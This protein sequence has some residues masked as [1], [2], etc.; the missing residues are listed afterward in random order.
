MD[1]EKLKVVD[2][3][4]ELSKRGLD[5]KGV[6]SVLVERLRKAIDEENANQDQS[7]TNTEVE[8]DV[9][10]EEEERS[11]KSTKIPQT[12]KKSSRLSK[13][14]AVVTPQREDPTIKKRRTT[15]TPYSRKQTSPKKSDQNDMSRESSPAVSESTIQEEASTQ[16]ETIMP[17]ATVLIEKMVQ[18]EK[19]IHEEKTVPKEKAMQEDKVEK[20]EETLKEEK[21]I[22]EN[23]DIKEE[24]T[25]K[26][27]RT[28]KEEGAGKGD[29]TPQEEITIKE[30]KS[31]LPEKDN[32][33]E[34]KEPLSNVEHEGTNIMEVQKE[35]IKDV[36]IEENT[37]NESKTNISQIS[38]VQSPVKS[39]NIV[40]PTKESKESE[41]SKNDT[42]DIVQNQKQ[43]ETSKMEEEVLES[44]GAGKD[45]NITTHEKENDTLKVNKNKCDEMDNSKVEPIAN[46]K[47]D[48]T[49]LTDAKS[50]ES[51]CDTQSDIPK[52]EQP[53]NDTT[54]E[55]KD[56]D[57][58][59]SDKME[60][61][62]QCM[63]K[64]ILPSNE[65]EMDT[66]IDDK[67]DKEDVEM[68]EIKHKEDT[69]VVTKARRSKTTVV[70]R[71]RKRKRSP[72]PLEDRHDSPP[73]VL[74]EN[75]PDID[76]AALILSWYDSDL[77]LVI[78][79]EGFFTATPMHNDGFS[80]MWA[81]ARASYGFLC[82]KVYYEAK[83]VDHCPVNTENEEYPHVLRIGW[84]TPYTSMQLGEEK[85]SF[86]YCSTGKKLTDNNYEDYGV[87]FGK[88][89]IIGCYF[90]ATSESDVVLTYT[91]NGKDQGIAFS[92]SKQ[93]LGDK[94]LFPHILSKNCSFACN[95]GQETP[96]TEEILQD[97]VSI[98]NV[99]SQ[100][101][102]PGPRRPE[103]KEECEVIMMC[104]LPAC[105]KTTWATKYAAEHP[106]KMYNVLGLGNLIDKMKDPELSDKEEYDAQWKILIQKC[107]YALDKLLEM[108]SSR[109][110]NYILDQT[111]VYPS[112]QRRKMKNFCGYQRKAIVLVPSEEEFKLRTAN[113]KP[114]EGKEIT[115]S[116]LLE[117]KANF[118]AP[119]VGDCFD[120]VNWIEL[121]QEEG[122]KLIEQYNKEGKE[123]GYGQQQPIKIPRIDSRSDSGRDHRNDSRNS[124][125]SRD[126]RDYRDRRNN[127][128]ERN[129]NPLWRG[130]GNTSR[131]DRPQRGHV[132]HGGG[133]GPPIPRRGRGTAIPPVHRGM[134][135]RGGGNLDRR[136][137]NERGRSLSS[138]HCGWVPMWNYQGSQQSGW[139]QGNWS[140]GQ[141][142]G[143]WGQ[144]NNWGSQQWGNWRGYG[145]G[146]YAQ[147]NYNQGYG[148]GNCNSWNQQYYNQYWGQQQPSGQTTTTTATTSSRQTT[149]KQ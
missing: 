143:G 70:H 63:E 61:E 26:E 84:S 141:S 131:R 41:E 55:V 42:D 117:M 29:K 24:S 86:G 44:S 62:D 8:N 142:Q 43:A 128:T 118:R 4:I 91:V 2:L 33:K 47:K 119:V 23:K 120:I 73:P 147:S 146:S 72:S 37:E 99:E 54:E 98:G 22:K 123:A 135:R 103:R 10:Q 124:R 12:P 95:F 109:R 83:I 20:V 138:R 6:K 16:E 7:K 148:N 108:A 19:A 64:D 115:E 126:S 57:M 114:I 107:T 30:E 78:D 34:T 144:Q 112:A 136:A 130:G 49:N 48:D 11:T 60:T 50:T 137:G 85:F 149:N 27:E 133:Y 81:G 116:M 110:R 9:S 92:I 97:Y 21:V 127:Y 80:H 93:E 121:D 66:N 68:T 100:Y 3:R 51:V 28:E 76:D 134:D 132:R 40:D 79:K 96:W 94:P 31:A 18:E 74:V 71:D 38:V 59:E 139:N 88:D 32:Q 75:E 45:K 35:E 69:D 145:Q 82:G 111:N 25:E 102:I 67:H 104:G 125:D 36:D 113:H 17:E 15:R 65:K 52:S 140:S 87:Q 56:T 13:G 105:G 14:A 46:E 106:H 90:D 89:D 122:T 58:T 77:N 5:T 1:P 129:R 39:S 53:Q 101:K